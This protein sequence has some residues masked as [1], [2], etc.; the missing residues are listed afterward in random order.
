M[1]RKLR[2]L[3]LPDKAQEMRLGRNFLLA[4]RNADVHPA[5]ART[6]AREACDKWRECMRRGNKTDAAYLLSVERA[7][8]LAYL[9]R[10]G[11]LIHD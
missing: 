9:L 1:S 8:H 6:L 3:K 7:Q 11:E 2:P 5:V 4:L 10:E